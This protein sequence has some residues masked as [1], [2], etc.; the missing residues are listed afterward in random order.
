VGS[1]SDAVFKFRILELLQ[2]TALVVTLCALGTLDRILQREQ[3]CF[4]RKQNLS[5][6][7][8]LERNHKETTRK[9]AGIEYIHRLTAEPS[10]CEVK[11]NL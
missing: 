3:T 8:Q 2:K 6:E 11:Y 4:T 7:R 10:Y 1:E 5:V 9:L